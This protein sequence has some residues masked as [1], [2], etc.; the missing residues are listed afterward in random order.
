MAVEDK[1]MSYRIYLVAFGIFLMAMAVVFKLS[2]IQWVEGEHYRKLA[3]EQTVKDFVIPANKGNIY[4]SDGSLLAT[5]IPNYTIRFDAVAP[6]QEDFDKN[7]K[8]L[9]DSLS[10]MLGKPSSYYHSELRKAHANKNRYYLLAKGLSY[11]EYMRLKTFPLFNLGTYKGGMI[12]EQKTVREHPIGKIAE[13]TIGYERVKPN[14]ELDGKGIEWSFRKYLNGKD[15]KVSKQK[16]A[17]GQW[18]PIRDVN[19]VDPQDGYDVISTIDV[20]IQDIAHHALLKQLELYEADHGC[21]VVMETQTGHVKAISNLGR[22]EDGSYYETVNYAVAESHEP[23]S[24]FKLVDLIALL[25]DNKVDTSQVYDSRGGEITYYGRKVR[26]SHKGGYGKISLARGFEVSSNTVL[27]QAVYENYKNNPKEFVDRIDRMGLNK[28]LGLPFQGE[29]KPFIPQPGEKGWSGI[30]LPW[31]AYGYGVSVTPLQTLALYNAI[32][33]NGEMVK[34][35]FVS[36]IKEW[37]KTIKK[38]NKQVINPRICSQET[39]KKVKAVLENVVK[40]G[41]GSKLY[42][43]DFSMAGKTG[44]AQ[45]N[46]SR[47]KDEMYYASSFV[48]FFPSDKPKYSCIVVVH[49]PNTAKNNYY[50]ADVAGPVFKRIAQKIFTDAPST[51][52]IKNLNKKINKQEV[53]YSVYNDKI[54]SEKKVVPNLK[55][56]AGMDAIALLENLKIKVKIIGTGKVKKQSIQPG[57]ALEKVKTITLELS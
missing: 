25:D 29:G 56:M 50:G 38:Y 28:P 6:K 45:V 55:G 14:G 33:N 41:T 21:V 10:V 24:T 3:A 52:E 32:A 1:Q 49:K 15:G 16:I 42:S 17:K 18:K 22:A 34:P 48:G 2:R 7:V 51:N 23:G 9:A 47:G 4:S 36:E 11:T 53:A 37:N 30:A 27:V 54:N 35:I 26:D 44:T 12:T 46:Y 57:E 20:Y 31:M 19:E 5:S 43:K 39:V 40:K 13:R 8:G